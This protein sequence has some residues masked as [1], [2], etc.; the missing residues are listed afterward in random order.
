MADVV[1]V[2]K[3]FSTDTFNDVQH[4]TATFGDKM[5][6]YMLAEN[7]LSVIFDHR[8]RGPGARAGKAKMETL[9]LVCTSEAVGAAHEEENHP[10]AFLQIRDRWFEA[11]DQ[12]IES[13]KE[14]ILSIIP[15]MNL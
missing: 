5:S 7:S 14:V 4:Q 11:F 9:D 2:R 3:G 1:E 8:A 13:M 6:R 12:L 10:A 15:S